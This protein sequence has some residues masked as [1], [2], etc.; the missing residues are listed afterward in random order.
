[1]FSFEPCFGL[2]KPLILINRDGYKV[3]NNK[4]VKKIATSAIQLNWLIRLLKR[5]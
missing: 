5:V 1:M 3:S 2:G 4:R